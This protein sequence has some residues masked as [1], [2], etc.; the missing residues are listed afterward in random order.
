MTDN[1]P[2]FCNVLDPQARKQHRPFSCPDKTL[3]AL[4]QLGALRLNVRRCMLM[5]FNVD[6]ACVLAEA[7]R[8]LSLE[9][10]SVHDQDDQL[11]LGHATIPRDVACCEVTVNLPAFP[12]H[13]VAG[14]KADCESVFVVNDLTE[15]SQTKDKPFV[16]NHPHGRFY[17]GVPITSPAGI[18][19][20]AYCVLDDEP[21]D[22]ISQR[23]LSFMRDMS[24]TVMAHLETLRARS[25]RQRVVHMVTGLGAFV[26]GASDSRKWERRIS[27][28]RVR[29]GS[30]GALKHSNLVSRQ[31]ERVIEHRVPNV[32]R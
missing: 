24:Q 15:N 30:A 14:S 5:F 27:K 20:G 10:D 23:D 17:A 29:T 19:I 22:G 12:V 7:T 13:S 32:Y 31:S 18:N 26:Q 16:T 25:E 4:C 9:D 8:S 11:W 28:R 3:T 21:R 1:G 2:S 6:N